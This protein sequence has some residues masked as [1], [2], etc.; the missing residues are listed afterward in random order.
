MTASNFSVHTFVAKPCYLATTKC[1]IYKLV[2]NIYYSWQNMSGCNFPS[3][4]NDKKNNYRKQ[5][6]KYSSIVMEVTTLCIYPDSLKTGNSVVSKK[7][8]IGIIQSRIYYRSLSLVCDES[9]KIM[10]ETNVRCCFACV[11]FLC[12]P[13]SQKQQLLTVY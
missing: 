13:L 12:D 6:P 11:S 10:C 4:R 5:K 1:F 9:L 7:Q 2:E 3:N 8:I